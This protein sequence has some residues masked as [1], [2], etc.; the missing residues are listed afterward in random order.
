MEHIGNHFSQAQ[1][2]F[3]GVQS[4][5]SWVHHPRRWKFP[6]RT[7]LYR[8]RERCVAGVV[9]RI[10]MENVELAHWQE[11]RRDSGGDGEVEGGLYNT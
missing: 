11:T 1:R 6:C 5:F 7:T 9:S 3:N 4:L 8:S 10:T 2:A